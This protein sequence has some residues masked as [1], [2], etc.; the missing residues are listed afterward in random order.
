MCTMGIACRAVLETYCGNDPGQLR[1]MFVRFSKPVFPGETIRIEF[2]NEPGVV[3]FR[4]VA[5]ERGAVVLDR[6]SARVGT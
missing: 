4:G 1:S 2:F 3:R 6:C 5:V